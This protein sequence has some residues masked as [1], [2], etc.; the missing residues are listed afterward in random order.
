MTLGDFIKVLL[1]IVEDNHHNWNK[2]IYVGGC[3]HIDLNVY[4]IDDDGEIN[5]GAKD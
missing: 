3:S 1:E 5:L 4:K 2:E